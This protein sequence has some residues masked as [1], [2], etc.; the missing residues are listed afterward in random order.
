MSEEFPQYIFSLVKDVTKYFFHHSLYGRGR[1]KAE[2]HQLDC[3]KAESALIS[4]NEKGVM[5]G[6]D[7]IGI[8]KFQHQKNISHMH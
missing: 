3:N 5:L 7:R 6:C 1:K 8:A 2:L 4:L